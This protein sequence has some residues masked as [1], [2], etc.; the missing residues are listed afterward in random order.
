MNDHRTPEQ[1]DLLVQSG[2]LTLILSEYPTVLTL[3]DV[4]KEVGA[5]SGEIATTEAV[6]ELTAL[7]L[8]HREGSLVLPTRAALHFLKIA[9]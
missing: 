6:R 1:E 9:A 2:V 3:G 8:F 4:I 5:Q 7:G